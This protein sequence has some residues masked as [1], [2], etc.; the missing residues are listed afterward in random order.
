MTDIDID[1][2]AHAVEQRMEVYLHIAKRMVMEQFG[3][4]AE[5][6][7]SQITVDLAAAMMQLEAAHVINGA[8]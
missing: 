1:E 7:H 2:R 5:H 8:Q 6:T 4:A 3:P